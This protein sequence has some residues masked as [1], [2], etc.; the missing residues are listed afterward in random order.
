LAFGAQVEYWAKLGRAIENTP[1]FGLDRVRETMEGRLRVEAVPAAED[2]ELFFTNLS[3]AFDTPDIATQSHD[4]ALGERE[5]AVGSDG[6]GGVVRRQPRL[7]LGAAKKWRSAPARPV[8]QVIAGPN[9]AGKT[10]FYETYLK[11]MA[12]TERPP[13]TRRTQPTN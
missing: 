10:T 6:E 12:T 1:G 5:G 9:G 3:A 13:V 11:R 7:R 8:L 2:R 4:A